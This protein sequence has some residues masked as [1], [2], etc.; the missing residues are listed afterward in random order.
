MAQAVPEKISQ[1]DSLTQPSSVAVV[2]IVDGDA[3]YKVPIT[4]LVVETDIRQHGTLGTDDDSAVLTRALAATVSGGTVVIPAGV[5]ATIEGVSVSDREIRGP[6]T[7]KYKA[8][9]ALPLCT[10][11]GAAR[12]NG[13]TIDG[14]RDNQSTNQSAILTSVA[15]GWKVIGC[16]F[17]SFRARVL[18]TSVAD[19][20]N[21]LV[22]GCTFDGIGAS[23]V[24]CDAVCIRSPACTVSNSFFNDLDDG[25]CVRVGLFNGDA[26]GTPVRGTV[27][28][29]NH[30]TNTNHV[31][32]TCEIYAQ[33]TTICGNEFYDLE[34]AIK[35]ESAGSTV[36]GVAITGNTIRGIGIA[37]ALNLVVPGVT[38]TGN[39][40][41]DLPAGPIF[42][43]AATCEGNYFERCGTAATSTTITDSGS[44][45]VVIRGNQLIDSPYRAITVAGGSIV[46]GNR[47]KNAGDSAIRISGS[48]ASVQGNIIDGCT[49]GVNVVSGTTNATVT[50][51]TFLAFSS[52]AVSVAAAALATCKVRDNIG[53]SDP[54]VTYTI[55]SGSITVGP[56][57]SLLNIATEGGA[58]TDDLDTITAGRDGQVIIIRPNSSSQDP[59]VRDVATSGTGNIH[60]V[61]AASFAMLSSTYRMALQWSGTFWQELWR[62]TT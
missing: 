9:S 33:Y 50:N 15:D 17:H 6:G 51:N 46:E 52:S 45:N 35:C 39:Q 12:L 34:Q 30:F 41:Y 11:T 3:T 13:L 18:V 57:V 22:D 21:G 26:T 5:T 16:T 42:N 53:T 54:S 40:C 58:A 56:W 7:L 55:A 28:V 44:G 62:S 27:V 38:F 8:N 4:N 19:S 59:T 36:W 1:L 20:P 60:T 2:P 25:H 10:L 31:G 61:G 24:G 23:G 49:I 14:N 29:G 32:V 47:I 48:G 37:T 43:G